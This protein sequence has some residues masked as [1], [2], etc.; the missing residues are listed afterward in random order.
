MLI[1]RRHLQ[2]LAFACALAHAGPLPGF[3][4]DSSVNQETCDRLYAAILVHDNIYPRAKLPEKI[5]LNYKK[6]ELDEFYQLSLKLWEDGF[7]RKELQETIEKLASGKELSAAEQESYKAVRAKFKQLRFAFAAFDENHEYPELF[8]QITA[9]MGHF[10][11]ALTNEQW[12][13]VGENKKKLLALLRKENV[14]DIEKE[15]AAFRPSGRSSFANYIVEEVHELKELLAKPTVTP[16]E[17][18]EMR[19]V[20]SRQVA[21]FDTLQALAPS[22]YHQQVV[23]YLSTLNG[24]MG[25]MHDVLIQQSFSG[26]LDYRKGAITVPPDIRDSLSKLVE[27][28]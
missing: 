15:L 27:A 18:H 9:T 6:A 24:K 7:S 12:D 13:L 28:F 2:A 8:D 25:K 14:A 3:A 16:K 19:K 11:D 4:A 17:F 20:I 23:E 26:E 21:I 10:Q 5:T 1:R 22:S